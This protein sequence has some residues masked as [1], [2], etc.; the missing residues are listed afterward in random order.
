M[1]LKDVPDKNKITPMNAVQ[2]VNSPKF[3]PSFYDVQY[4]FIGVQGRYDQSLNNQENDW[5]YLQTLHE[6]VYDG[7][8]LRVIRRK[9]YI[10]FN[11]PIY[12]CKTM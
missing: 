3:K 2:S 8:H 5:T 6:T 1:I 10:T 4:F 12:H 9:R 7:D 11:V